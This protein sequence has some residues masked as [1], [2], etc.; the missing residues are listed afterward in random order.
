[1]ISL[2]DLYNS[3]Q[4]YVNTFQGGWFRPQTDFER[5]CNDISND[6]WEMWT[7]QAEKSQ[8]YNDN[9]S[10][11]LKSTNILVKAQNTYYGTF[12][13]PDDYGRFASARIIV[14][15]STCLPAK[16]VNEGKC[17]GFSLEEE[18]T[19]KLEDYYSKIKERLMEKIDNQRWGS[20]CEH[21]TKSP[22]LLNPKITQIEG[23]FKVAPRSVTVVVLDYYIRPKRAV[24]GYV[25]APGN[26]QTGAGDQLIYQQNLSTPLE[27]PSTV[28]NEFL[29][30]LGERYGFFTRDQFM[31]QMST[32]QKTMQ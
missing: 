12:S 26:V 15:G 24:F 21:R 5:A 10:P 9:L 31:A 20:V 6:L 18:K 11:F 30:R 22:S 13:P 2:F 14:A 25:V 28:V 32:Q 7:R 27:W 1:M 3:F 8:E 17:E 4:S 23:K 29:V 19:Q 16:E